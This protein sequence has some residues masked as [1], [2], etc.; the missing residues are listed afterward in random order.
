MCST[1][2]RTDLSCLHL[3]LAP[4]PWSN[5][6]QNERQVRR[7][8]ASFAISATAP[9]RLLRRRL[10]RRA[11]DNIYRIL[12]IFAYFA[13]LCCAS[14]AALHG[15]W[16]PF[17]AMSHPPVIPRQSQPPWKFYSAQVAAATVLHC[18][19]TLSYGHPWHRERA[20]LPKTAGPAQSPSRI[21]G[22]VPNRLLPPNT[23]R[24]AFL[25]R[26]R[27]HQVPDSRLVASFAP[28]TA[29]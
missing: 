25:A 7:N 18:A 28:L 22:S 20:A 26:S 3:P 11:T 5:S 12:F 1:W 2:A 6:L 9:L 14:W 16:L 15:F 24:T 4:R 10:S 8:P 13:L 21:V 17:F 29:Q 19:D 27:C 23:L